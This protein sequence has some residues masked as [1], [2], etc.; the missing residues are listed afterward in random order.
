MRRIG[1]KAWPA[2]SIAR[3][4]DAER[5]LLRPPPTFAGA[6]NAAAADFVPA[7]YEAISLMNHYLNDFTLNHCAQALSAPDEQRPTDQQTNRV[8]TADQ[9]PTSRKQRLET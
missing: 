2:K 5:P 9:R 4:A 8:P 1:C 6:T 3:T 7:L